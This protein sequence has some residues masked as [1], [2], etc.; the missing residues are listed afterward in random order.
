MSGIDDIVSSP[1]PIDNA[2]LFCEGDLGIFVQFV[3]EEV[4]KERVS[5]V[6]RRHINGGGVALAS[7]VLVLLFAVFVRIIEKRNRIEIENGPL[8]F[9]ELNENVALVGGSP[10]EIHILGE[11]I[12]RQGHDG[13]YEIIGCFENG[14]CM[15][16]LFWNLV[17]LSPAEFGRV[18]K[19]RGGEYLT[20]IPP[21]RLR[22][23]RG[24]LVVPASP[25]SEML[26]DS[27]KFPMSIDDVLFHD[28]RDPEICLNIAEPRCVDYRH[29]RFFF[30]VQSFSLGLF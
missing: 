1:W 27:F 13:Y 14:E 28:Y 4:V 18:W 19:E 11:V 22:R 6:L 26:F 20:Y 25:S 24:R 21:D 3:L 2:S 8:L 12:L 29:M 5:R 30:P 7:L 17:T 10:G 9:V 15:H 16:V 23:A